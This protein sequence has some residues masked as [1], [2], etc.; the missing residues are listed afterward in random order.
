MKSRLY[1]QFQKVSQLPEPSKR[2][3][4][5]KP[6]NEQ[7]PAP[8]AESLPRQRLGLLL[9]A[10]QMAAVEVTRKWTDQRAFLESLDA[11]LSQCKHCIY[12]SDIDDL[13]TLLSKF[14]TH[15]NKNLVVRG[16]SSVEQIVRAA[17]HDIG[18]HASSFA[19]H[20]IAAWSDNRANIREQATKAIDAF[21][22]HVGVSCFVR[23]IAGT[24]PRG[25]N[26]DFRFEAIKWINSHLG[27]IHG[28]DLERVIPLVMICV[29][30][31]VLATRQV[32][33]QV[34]TAIQEASPGIFDSH[35]Q[36]ISPSGRRGLEHLIQPE[37]AAPELPIPPQRRTLT[38]P[39][40]PELIVDET[41]ELPR[42]ASAPSAAKKVK[43]LR[44]QQAGLGLAMI[45]SRRVVSAVLE[46][47]K[48][49]ATAILPPSIVTRMFSTSPADQINSIEELRDLYRD[50]RAQIGWCSDIFVRWIATRLFEKNQKCVAEGLPFLMLVFSQEL[51]SLQELEILVPLVLWCVDSKPAHIADYALDLLVVIRAHSDRFDYSTVLR[52]CLES[53][54]IPALIHLFSEL[55]FTIIEHARNQ[56]ILVQLLPFLGHASVEVAAACGG[57]VAL[58]LRRITEQ[59]KADF[60]QTLSSRQ[61]EALSPFVPLET[62]DS[63]TPELFNRATSLEKVKLCRGLLDQIRFS[64]QAI[65]ST[66]SSVLTAL[67]H[68]ITCP[69]TDW[70]PMKLII[71][72]LHMLLLRCKFSEADLKQAFVSVAFFANRWQDQSMILN[73]IGQTVTAVLQKLFSAI[74]PA[75]LFAALLDGMAELK[76]EIA[77]DSFYC[78]CWAAVLDQ[79][80]AL[81]QASDSQPLLEIAEQGRRRFGSDIRG[82][83]CASLT[84]V[85][86][87]RLPRPPERR[88]RRVGSRSAPASPSRPVAEPP[89]PAP[90]D[91]TPLSPVKRAPA[92]G[93]QLA[94]LKA[95]LEALRKRWS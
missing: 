93:G 67:L 81:Q 54:S 79:F 50:D 32:A 22:V 61:R 64:G 46:R 26:S 69:Q 76:G 36:S 71:F 11:A 87:G 95:R 59:E 72:S 70:H 83:L 49:D 12:G 35:I 20:L 37:M 25:M 30:D 90:A 60:C 74:P 65:Q 9:S 88:A 21:V 48:S 29:Q 3:L 41:K 91:R 18:K 13:M 4:R 34:S 23:A 77:V 2:F 82:Q 75:V 63:I 28:M 55:Q 86:S 58:L 38:T 56:A 1:R 80:T 19:P 44:R 45:T 17:D 62:Y 14:V 57:V 10:E 15:G 85:V 92:D 89:R 6:M 51:L 84:R 8:T 53:S 68:E 43:R 39:A 27:L 78:K 7:P 42:Y 73:G 31:L 24:A 40:M 52:S 94:D 47:L 5:Q 16:L 66:A 33:I